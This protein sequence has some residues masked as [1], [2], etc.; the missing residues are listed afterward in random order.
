[1]SSRPIA[2]PR[3]QFQVL[4]LLSMCGSIQR[5]LEFLALRRFLRDRNSSGHSCSSSFTWK[6]TAKGKPTQIAGKWSLADDLLTLAQA[7]QGGALV[8]HVAGPADGKWTFRAI[9]TGPEDPG[10][11]FTR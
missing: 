4:H 6:V 5:R 7:G 9:G 2:A 3:A 8:G 10:L 11:A 1:M